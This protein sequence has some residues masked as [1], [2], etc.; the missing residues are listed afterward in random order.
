MCSRCEVEPGTLPTWQNSSDYCVVG[1]Q[2]A[3][4]MGITAL[5]VISIAKASRKGLGFFYLNV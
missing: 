1:E 2:L 3:E 4:A 5:A